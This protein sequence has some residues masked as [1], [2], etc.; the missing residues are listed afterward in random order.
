MFFEPYKYNQILKLEAYLHNSQFTL[1]GAFET[2]F[3]YIS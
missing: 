2:G 1:Y 3:F